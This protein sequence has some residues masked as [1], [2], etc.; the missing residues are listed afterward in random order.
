[1]NTDIS[2]NSRERHWLIFSA[3]FSILLIS[4]FPNIIINAVSGQVPV[5]LSGAKAGF[6]VLFLGLCFILKNLKLLRPYAFVMFIFY[7]SLT[8]SEWIRSSTWWAGLIN[9]ETKPSFLFTYLKPFIRDT[10]VTLIVI[11]ALWIVKRHRSGF[12]LVIGELD[13]PVEPMH[14]MG[15]RQGESWRTF[16]WIFALVAT[17]VVAIP[18]MIAIR[19]SPDIFLRVIPMIPAIL[20][21]AAINAFNEE[22][23][24]RVTLL[25]TLPQVIGKNHALLINVVFFGLAHYL[26]GSPPGIVGFLMTGFLALLLGKSM[27]E[28]KGFCWPWFIHFLPDV[29]IFFSYAITWVR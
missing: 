21:F 23:Y 22:I 19:P 4:D 13:A 14:W 9:V 27:L 29:V 1:M 25:S 15:I 16:G 8:A 28:T 7:T 3:W 12:F 18:V 5:W 6:L 2:Q 20:L 24:F 17:L 26:Y 10:G 11:A